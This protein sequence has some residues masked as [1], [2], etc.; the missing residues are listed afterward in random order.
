MKGLIAISEAIGVTYASV[1]KW[2]KENPDRIKIEGKR[3]GKI[4]SL[5]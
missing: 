5:N 3:K 2:L 4:V 1:V